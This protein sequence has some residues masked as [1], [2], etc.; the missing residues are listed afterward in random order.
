MVEGTAR[1]FWFSPTA[2][3]VW[4]SPLSQHAPIS[5][6]TGGICICIYESTT[7]FVGFDFFV[8]LY[9]WKFNQIFV[10]FQNF[11]LKFNFKNPKFCGK[12]F[13]I[14]IA[15]A[16]LP[17][18]F[19]CRY[20]VESPIWLAAKGRLKEYRQNPFNHSLFFCKF[21]Q[22]RL[23]TFFNRNSFWVYRFE[24]SHAAFCVIARY[25]GKDSP[26]PIKP[27][28]A[29]GDQHTNQN[30]EEPAEKAERKRASA[31]A[32]NSEGVASCRNGFRDPSES[33]RPE[34]S[35]PPPLLSPVQNTEKVD[36]KRQ[37][38]NLQI[39]TEWESD[40]QPLVPAASVKDPEPET[41]AD[42]AG[43]DSKP[44]SP[45]F[46]AAPQGLYLVAS[47]LSL[48]FTCMGFYGL[49]LIPD[50]IGDLYFTTFLGALLEIPSTV[51]VWWL[52]AHIGRRK[53]TV[54]VFL[55]AGNLF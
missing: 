26:P 8:N 53:P 12:R 27:A 17:D 51:L 11:V 28:A 54:W 42:G 18:L 40:S 41:V 2:Y 13:P 49:Y 46:L 3:G 20:S 32:A 55:I 24:E 21:S 38:D 47:C 45:G 43:A 48:L 50:A 25:N 6:P 39:E 4:A 19:F 31:A 16:L 29:A 14:A 33:T 30:P 10:I 23:K 44:K 1:S 5:S 9:F 15:V 35:H 52:L 22:I 36:K 34:V 7:K 37:T